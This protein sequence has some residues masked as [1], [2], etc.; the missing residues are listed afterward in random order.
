MFTSDSR[1]LATGSKDGTVRLWDLQALNS[2]P[3]PAKIF[4]GNQN[5]VGF[6]AFDPSGRWLAAAAWEG[7]LR[8]WDLHNPDVSPAILPDCTG[9][10]AFSPDG[11]WLA[12]DC[13]KDLTSEAHL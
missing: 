6:L 10:I 4:S 11:K 1:W 12:A 13:Y 9:P 3:A 7:K 2:T 8:V 5:G